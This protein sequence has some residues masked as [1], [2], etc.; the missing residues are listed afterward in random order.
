MT[1]S[2]DAIY[3]PLDRFIFWLAQGFELPFIVAPDP[4]H[5][6]AHAII[7]TRPVRRRRR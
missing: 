4:D 2:F 1:R 5:H 6:G 3:A 7:L